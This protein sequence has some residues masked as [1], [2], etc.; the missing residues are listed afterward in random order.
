MILHA[1]LSPELSDSTGAFVGKQ[2]FERLSSSPPG[3]PQDGRSA[4]S[5]HPVEQKTGLVGSAENQPELPTRSAPSFRGVLQ[6][7]G[8][9]YVWVDLKEDGTFEILPGALTETRLGTRPRGKRATKKVAMVTAQQAVKS[10]GADGQRYLNATKPIVNKA[11][12]FVPKPSISSEVYGAKSDLKADV[13]YAKA[14]LASMSHAER[15]SALSTRGIKVSDL[16]RAQ[17]VIELARLDHSA[18]RF[19]H[20]KWAQAK[21]AVADFRIRHGQKDEYGDYTFE[22]EQ[23]AQ[24]EKLMAD[25]RAFNRALQAGV[26]SRTRRARMIRSHLNKLNR[27]DE[28][29]DRNTRRMVRQQDNHSFKVVKP[30][31][32]L[33]RREP[34]YRMNLDEL[35]SR[36]SP[37]APRYSP[38][39]FSPVGGSKIKLVSTL[40]EP[41]TNSNDDF[42]RDAHKKREQLGDLLTFYGVNKKNRRLLHWLLKKENSI[43]VNV[44]VSPQQAVCKLMIALYEEFKRSK[45]SCKV[46]KH[47]KMRLYYQNKPDLRWR[48]LGVI[49]PNT[50][51]RLFYCGSTDGGPGGAD[52]NGAAAQ[53]QAG[54]PAEYQVRD[55]KSRRKAPG[56]PRSKDSNLAGKLVKGPQL[57][58]PIESQ[59]GP[60]PEETVENVGDLLCQFGDREFTIIGA[61]SSMMSLWAPRISSHDAKASVVV[62]GSITDAIDW[63][64]VRPEGM[65][66][67]VFPDDWEKVRKWAQHGDRL[68]DTDI[69]DEVSTIW[70]GKKYQVW[71]NDFP[72]PQPGWDGGVL[73]GRWYCYDRATRKKF[74]RYVMPRVEGFKTTN[75]SRWVSPR[76]GVFGYKDTPEGPEPIADDTHV[77]VCLERPVEQDGYTVLTSLEYDPNPAFCPF[78]I[79]DKTFYLS[80]EPLPIGF[81]ASPTPWKSDQIT[82]KISLFLTKFPDCIMARDSFVESLKAACESRAYASR[83]NRLKNTGLSIDHWVQRLFGDNKYTRAIVGGDL[84]MSRTAI[85]NAQEHFLVRIGANHVLRIVVKAGMVVVLVIVAGPIVVAPLFQSMFGLAVPCAISASQASVAAVILVGGAASGATI[86]YVV[87]NKRRLRGSAKRHHKRLAD[88]FRKTFSPF[89]QV[90]SSSAAITFNGGPALLTVE[91]TGADLRDIVANLVVYF[92]EPE[93][94]I[95]AI[96]QICGASEVCRIV[97]TEVEAMIPS[98]DCAKPLPPRR[99]KWTIL[100]HDAEELAASY[101]EHRQLIVRAPLCMYPEQSLFGVPDGIYPL[102]FVA[103]SWIKPADTDHNLKFTLLGRHMKENDC[104]SK[105]QWQTCQKSRAISFIMETAREAAERYRITEQEFESEVTNYTDKCN[106]SSYYKSLVRRMGQHPAS[107]PHNVINSKAMR[108]G[109]KVD[110]TIAKSVRSL[111]LQNPVPAMAC[112]Y[113]V[114]ATKIFMRIFDLTFR[115]VTIADRKW[116]VVLWACPGSVAS[117][118]EEYYDCFYDKIGELRTEQGVGVYVAAHHGDDF[119]ARIW[120]SE[121]DK[122]QE[123]ETDASNFDSCVHNGPVEAMLELCSCFGVPSWVV[124]ILSQQHY[125]DLVFKTPGRGILN[126][127]FRVRSSPDHAEQPTGASS[128]TFLNT[129]FNMFVHWELA[130]TADTD[131]W[132]DLAKARL[133]VTLKLQSF[134]HDGLVK[135]LSSKGTF[136]RGYFGTD[137]ENNTVYCT[138]VP[139]TVLKAISG[140]RSSPIQVVTTRRWH[141][142]HLPPDAQADL[143][144]SCYVGAMLRDIT[145]GNCDQFA[146]SLQAKLFPKGH[147][148]KLLVRANMGERPL[149]DGL[150]EG[151]TSDVIANSDKFRAYRKYSA[152]AADIFADGEN[153]GT[154]VVSDESTDHFLQS[155]YGLS[156]QQI[157]T[158]IEHLPPFCTRVFVSNPELCKI[159]AA[160]YAGVDMFA[161]SREFFANI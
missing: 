159:I 121:W 65:I 7:I 158:S 27:K 80:N 154:D 128:T 37:D 9:E 156:L 107:S 133:G 23:A 123:I 35:I 68:V 43:Q 99:N 150:A 32:E 151:D 1:T 136:L 73:P 98:A 34:R 112:M 94:N 140:M 95:E 129:L 59:P 146:L 46:G 69:S 103:A 13:E 76:G 39:T 51:V 104:D 143:A 83:T 92:L 110:E 106:K 139:A 145:N 54:V 87:A 67:Y 81:E 132:V 75:T 115:E 53:R 108:K 44:R 124:S 5:S 105:A 116:H 60:A 131:Q 24:L 113:V 58:E 47:D 130:S 42:D 138:K 38:E 15:A 161:D 152:I 78:T 74:H 141:F 114:L 20:K 28:L 22:P 147:L 19:Y 21:K 77:Y 96:N 31:R 16:S 111:T 2:Q 137:H 45:W 64:I 50:E 157:R 36:A 12:S 120:K 49:E 66:V 17:G 89:A 72:F 3:E 135:P 4:T 26:C 85:R 71:T 61:T 14:S 57:A 56:A 100:D 70:A 41:E 102:F 93:K 117:Q 109:P 62:R 125:G 149:S 29:H 10:M 48:E 91:L 148:Q 155:R 6:R 126:Q 8:S 55:S 122:H 84:H 90:R 18:S 118:L 153:R 11:S 101:E 79:A 119:H 25:V 52:V 30:K 144:A 40:Q 160:D 63:P 127:S 142:K 88:K 82:G 33:L 134:V 86:A 97:G